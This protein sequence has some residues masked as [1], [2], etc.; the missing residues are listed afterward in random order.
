MKERAA[1]LRAGGKIP[2]DLGNYRAEALDAVLAPYRVP[3]CRVSTTCGIENPLPCH[4]NYATP[5]A[6]HS[7]QPAGGLIPSVRKL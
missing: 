3:G 6:K 2:D 4:G 7:N 5:H 1:E